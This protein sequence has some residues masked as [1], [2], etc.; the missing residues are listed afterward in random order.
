M[1]IIGPGLTY[2]F[3]LSGPFESANYLSLYLVPA[4]L[5]CA[6]YLYAERAKPSR[7]RYFNVASFTVIASALFFTKSYA[8]VLAV[9]GA[10][11][12]AVM[13]AAIRHYGG[14]KKALKPLG[15]LVLLLVIFV[16]TQIGSNKFKLFLDFENRSSTTVRLQ[17]Y[18]TSWALIKEHPL[19]GVGPGL[20]QPYYQV[21]A[22]YVLGQPPYEWNMPHPHNIFLAFWLNSGILGL[23]AF[24]G[25]VIWVH[26]KGS[27]ALIPL[28]GILIHGLFD[29]PFWKNDLA[30]I[31]WLILAMAVILRIH[32]TSSSQKQ[33]A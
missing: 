10:L 4:L 1:A 31:F 9:F 17:I 28:W 8:A 19:L 32:A 11:S 30:M 29:V 23:L 5:L 12:I 3:R 21:K 2:D 16:A 33:S 22:P 14:L 27:Y 7:N 13:I 15:I 18:K 25:L 24:V 20:F 6:Y 26:L